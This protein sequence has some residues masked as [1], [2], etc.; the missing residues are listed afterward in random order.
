MENCTSIHTKFAKFGINYPRVD[1]NSP[2]FAQIITVKPQ[3]INPKLPLGD[4]D[5]RN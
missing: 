3:V 2:W 4:N 5:I 1:C